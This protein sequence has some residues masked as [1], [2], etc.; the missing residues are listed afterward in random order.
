MFYVVAF[1]EVVYLVDC[2]PLTIIE[3]TGLKWTNLNLYDQKAI[4]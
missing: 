2:V 1:V 3:L 4:Y